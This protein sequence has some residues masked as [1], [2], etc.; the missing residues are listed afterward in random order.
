MGALAESWTLSDDKM[1]WTFKLR[2]GVTFHDGTRFNAEAVESNFLTMLD[3]DF[4][5]YYP[6]AAGT[7]GFTLTH[8]DS[9]NVVDEFTF[10]VRLKYPFFGLSN[11]RP[12]CAAASSAPP[13]L[14]MRALRRQ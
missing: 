4:E 14:G 7:A 10:Q 5:Y 9:V 12:I 2:Q 3:E 6:T 1:T 8:V 13:P 11:C